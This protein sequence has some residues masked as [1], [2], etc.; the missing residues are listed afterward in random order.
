MRETNCFPFFFILKLNFLQIEVIQKINSFDKKI[1]ENE[2]SCRGLFNLCA[3]KKYLT[4][5]FIPEIIEI[6]QKK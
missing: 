5:Y 4:Y 2:F 1:F 6:E 3:K